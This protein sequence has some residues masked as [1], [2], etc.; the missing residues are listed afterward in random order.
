M[1][2]LQGSGACMARDTVLKKSPIKVV[3]GVVVGLSGVMARAKDFWR[4]YSQP[5][6]NR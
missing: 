3:R 1:D 4:G 2:F 5:G 6:S